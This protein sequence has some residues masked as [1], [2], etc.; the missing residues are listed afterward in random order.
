MAWNVTSKHRI[1]KRN[2]CPQLHPGN[3]GGRLTKEGGR[4]QQIDGSSTYE[5]TKNKPEAKCKDKWIKQYH[6]KKTDDENSQETS[7]S[8]LPTENR[9]MQAGTPIEPEAEICFKRPMCHR[10]HIISSCVASYPTHLIKG[11]SQI[12]D[13]YRNSTMM[14]KTETNHRVCQR[15]WCR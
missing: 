12:S 8:N 1:L 6:K 5:E 9:I 11:S 2:T 14:L 3:L 4:M 15:E 13:P 10:H 7:K